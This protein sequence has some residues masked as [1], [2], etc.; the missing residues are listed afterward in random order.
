MAKKSLGKKAPKKLSELPDEIGPTEGEL[1]EAAAP[2][3]TDKPEEHALQTASD[4]T[5][6]VAGVT[7]GQLK[8]AL[9][10]Q[11]E[12]RALIKDFIQTH[13]V[14]G[15]D[16][17]RIHFSK[18]CTAEN[19]A[20]GS[21]DIDSHHSKRILYKPGQEKI[22][23]LFSLT[24]SLERDDQTMEML[25]E[26][27]NLVAYKCIAYRTSGG[28][29][30]VVAEG[31]GAAVVGDK[32]RDVNA[33]IKIAE[34]RARMDACLAMGFSEYFAQD[35]DDPDYQNQK[36]MSDERERARANAGDDT[37]STPVDKLP[38][39]DAGLP[40]DQTERTMLARLMLRLGIDT[41]EEQIE[42]IKINGVPEPKK[43]TSGQIRT[44]MRKMATN[45]FAKPP[46]PK[47]DDDVSD[48]EVTDESIKKALDGADTAPEQP[49]AE[50]P[51]EPELVVDE[52]FKANVVEWFNS[53]GFNGWG[54][55]WFMKRISGRPFG[56]FGQ[57]MEDG[58]WQ[59]AFALLQAILHDQFP[60]EDQ[61]LES[62]GAQL[63]APLNYS[64]PSNAAERDHAAYKA[65]K[66][67]KKAKKQARVA[68]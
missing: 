35:L 57:N 27:R 2:G 59:K 4:D 14:N 5:S 3:G 68:A 22:F 43:I 67:T 38:I 23:S 54:T 39:R 45:A 13:L 40:A 15:T 51:E 60:V 6:I 36:R 58:V 65:P 26:T 64:E 46:E 33:T 37:P 44:L 55:N 20:P 48:D 34:K 56:K 31:R 61:Y 7:T 32:S 28:K 24:S 25:S 10:T 17:G 66:A 53:V 18:N 52:E 16:F 29:Q 42:V 21:C 19:R 41:A 50:V 62:P 1:I 47:A 8:E 11:T 9:T 49:A 12:Q 30:V 63:Q